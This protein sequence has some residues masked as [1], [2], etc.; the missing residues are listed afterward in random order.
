[1]IDPLT[2]F[3]VSTA[4]SCVVKSILN[5][6]ENKHKAEMQAAIE[7]YQREALGR[8]HKAALSRLD[9]LRDIKLQILRDEW[10]N[11]RLSRQNNHNALINS[12]AKLSD[13]DN[14]PLS[15]PP[16][17]INNLPLKYGLSRPEIA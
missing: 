4:A 1:M 12:I 7:A 8:G 16:I 17:V 5:H 11:V 14:W 2:T 9:K 15:V 6:R 10:D 3:I 13:I